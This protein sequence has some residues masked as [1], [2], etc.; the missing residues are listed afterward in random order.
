MR[1]RLFGTIIPDTIVER[2]DKAADPRREGVRICVE[3]LHDLAAI[4]GV[5]GA[6][7]MA[8]QNPSAIA[9]VLAGFTPL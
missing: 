6:H 9:E 3:I 5:A 2:L 1:K 8:P 7:V 4:P